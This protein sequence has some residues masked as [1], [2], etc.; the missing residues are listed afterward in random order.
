MART[1]SAAGARNGGKKLTAFGEKLREIRK[2]RGLLLMDMANAV[3]VTPGFLSSVETGNKPIPDN[4][5]SRIVQST[6]LSD[7]QTAELQRAAALS[8][9]EYKIVMPEDAM[10]LDRQVA[11]ALETGFAKISVMKKQK[12][13]DLLE[14]E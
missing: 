11:F 2:E 9:K 12:I 7:R 1:R 5:L 14:E 13:L 8:A 4:L 6:N 10:Q 3:R